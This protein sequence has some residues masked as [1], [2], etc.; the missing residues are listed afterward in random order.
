ME[1]L[2]NW[3]YMLIPAVLYIAVQMS[4]NRITGTIFLIPVL[5]LPFILYMFMKNKNERFFKKLEGRVL[6]QLGFF[7]FFM[8]LSTAFLYMQS[9]GG[10]YID[11]HYSV[12]NMLS[13]VFAG[14][15]NEEI[16]YRGFIFERGKQIFETRTAVIVSSILF[17]AAHSGIYS[18]LM[19]IAAGIL[20][21]LIKIKY[22]NL[23]SS[24]FVHICVNALLLINSIYYFS[25]GVY[26]IALIGLVMFSAS[27][28]IRSNIN[29]I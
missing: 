12:L 17:G 24:I 15:V 21:C 13:I 8:A 28:F 20:L 29:K 26:F 19:S 1:K 10:A 14:P 22:K 3:I 23:S 18:I 11:D 2:Q 9:S 25:N 16:I 27:L 7:S 6:L 5:M 4:F